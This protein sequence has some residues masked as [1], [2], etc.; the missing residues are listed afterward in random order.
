MVIERYFGIAF[1]PADETDLQ[2]IIPMMTHLY[3]QD[4]IEFIAAE[5]MVALR[6]LLNRPEYGRVWLICE[7]ER[8]IGYIVLTIGYSIEFKGLDAFIDELFIIEQARGKGVG[9]VA[10]EFL[11]H[12]CREI[13]IGAVHLEVEH[14]NFSAQKFYR[15]V[16]FIDR[17]NYLMTR[18]TI[19]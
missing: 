3:E 13:G 9:K 1:K 7:E 15:K 4:Q 14:E 18:T 16:G 6:G 5:A 10:I 2:I 19:S 8:V 17:G 11:I 12:Q